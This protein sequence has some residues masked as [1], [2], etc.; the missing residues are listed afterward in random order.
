MHLPLKGVNRPG[1][2]PVHDCELTLRAEN[3]TPAL[4]DSLPHLIGVQRLA[5]EL[6]K[7]IGMASLTLLGPDLVQLSSLLHAVMHAVHVALQVK[8]YR[9]LVS[10]H[11]L[12]AGL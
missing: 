12:L 3:F 7:L 5:E 2:Q 8:G 10:T 9:L 11:A 6:I 4:A 1:S